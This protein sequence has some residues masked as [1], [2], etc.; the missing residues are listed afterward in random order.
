MKKIIILLLIANLSQGQKMT[1]DNKHLIAG[2][3]ITMVSSYVIHKITGKTFLPCI[4][5]LAIGIGSG[6]AKEYIWD[7]AIGKGVFNKQDYQSTTI[8][9]VIGYMS[10]QCLI[11]I[12]PK[13]RKK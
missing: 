1:D 8:G 7:R 4:D 9:S 10:I 2:V 6:Y 5:G 11:T 12:R 13:K 3:G